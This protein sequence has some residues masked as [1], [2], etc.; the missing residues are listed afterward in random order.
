MMAMMLVWQE[1]GR[2]PWVTVTDSS[3]FEACLLELF[4]CLQAG[5]W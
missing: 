5:A 4:V 2:L 1:N 3:D